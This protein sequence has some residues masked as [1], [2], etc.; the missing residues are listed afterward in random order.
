[1]AKFVTVTIGDL[2]RIPE[3]SSEVLESDIGKSLVA[4]LRAYQGVDDSMKLDVPEDMAALI[5]V[6]ATTETAAAADAA[7]QTEANSTAVESTTLEAEP[8][9]VSSE[10]NQTAVETSSVQPES[11]QTTAEASTPEVNTPTQSDVSTE[12]EPGNGT[13]ESSPGESQSAAA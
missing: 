11:S 6:P 2:R 12:A 1:M 9:A 10:T 7:A 4:T 8:N 5:P 13:A 3:P